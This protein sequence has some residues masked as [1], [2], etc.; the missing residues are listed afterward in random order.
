MEGRRSRQ[1]PAPGLARARRRGLLLP[2][3]LLLLLPTTALCLVGAVGG[4]AA[5]PGLGSQVAE[6]LRSA[7]GGTA[8]VLLVAVAEIVALLVC[9]P[10]YSA[11]EYAAGAVFGFYWATVIVAAAKCVACLLAYALI[12]ALKDSSWGQWAQQRVRSGDSSGRLALRIQK[13]I[14][15]GSFSFS[16]M[17]RCSPLPAWLTNYALPL[18][19]VPFSTYVAASFIGMLP[20]VLTNCYAGSLAASAAAALSGSSAGA[21]SWNLVGLLAVSISVLSSTKLVHQLS[22]KCAAEEE[23][24]TV[25]AA[26]PLL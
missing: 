15:E 22:T 11:I 4:A 9:L 24:G 2:L 7:G 20:P 23:D 26:A 8:S 14:K 19:G 17:V 1:F 12:T 16:L 18:A 5:R 13:G 6:W 21:G 3:A 10:G 25:P